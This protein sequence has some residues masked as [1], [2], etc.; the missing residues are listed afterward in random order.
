ML[1]LQ[2][3]GLASSGAKK[4]RYAATVLERASLFVGGHVFKSSFSS[5]S[6]GAW[7]AV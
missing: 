1:D 5:E 6:G 7:R 2:P 4:G 3:N